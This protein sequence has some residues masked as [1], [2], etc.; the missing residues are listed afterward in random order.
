MAKYLVHG[1]ITISALIEVEA[2]SEKEA[3][4][5]AAE[6]P[7]MGLCSYCVDQTPAGQWV[8]SGELDGSPSITTVATAE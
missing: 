2:N 6:A 5:Q 3:R 4:E 8:T 7:V 1:Q